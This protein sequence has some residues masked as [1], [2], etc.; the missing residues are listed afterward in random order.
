MLKFKT[1]FKTRF[2]LHFQK[3]YMLTLIKHQEFLRIIDI[4]E[5]DSFNVEAVY[6]NVHY[7]LRRIDIDDDNLRYGFSN[8]YYEDGHFRKIKSL[9]NFLK[10]FIYYLFLSNDFLNIKVFNSSDAVDQSENLINF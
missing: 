6:S 8:Y 9:S 10:Y 4:K 2:Q 5:K 7:M 1:F 3:Q